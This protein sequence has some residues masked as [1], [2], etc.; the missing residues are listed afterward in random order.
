MTEEHRR[1]E[2]ARNLNTSWRRCF[3]QL[4]EKEW[5]KNGFAF[6]VKQEKRSPSAMQEEPAQQVRG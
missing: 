3:G 1:L 4:N 6:G 5:L 2:A